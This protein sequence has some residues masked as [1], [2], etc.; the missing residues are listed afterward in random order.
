VDFLKEHTQATAAYVGKLVT[1]KKPI[2]ETDDDR[3]HIDN[4]AEKVIHFLKATDG[5]H[6]LVDKVLKQSQG[7]TFD[8]F[9]E[10]EAAAAE[11]EPSDEPPAEEESPR[12]QKDPEEALP[13]TIFVKEVVREPRMHFF[14]VPRLGS[15]LAVRLEY[16]SC[17]LE[18]A[19]DAAVQDSLEMRNK[20]KEQ[21]EEKKA[22]LEKLLADA[23]DNDDPNYDPHKVA[24]QRKWE[25]LKPK[26]YKSQNIQF[27]VCLNTLGQDREFTADEIK[28]AQRTVRDYAA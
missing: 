1:P 15:Y 27:V 10:A 19:L 7:L 28:F 18:E 3:A 13:R 17:L 25:E 4:D 2:K 8:V 12:K 9:K 22:Y 14:K 5:H 11:K 16:S 6:Y 21:E 24:A 23:K 26:P 20:L